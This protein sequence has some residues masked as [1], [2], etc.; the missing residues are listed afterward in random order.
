MPAY[1]GDDWNLAKDSNITGVE[2]LASLSLEA[3]VQKFIHISTL[4]VYG[5]PAE[6]DLDETSPIVLKHEQAY[7]ETKAESERI[8]ERYKE[9]GLCVTT[10]RPGAICAEE[11]SYWGD[12]QV[13]R[14]LATDVVNWVH[15]DDLVPW[16]HTDNLVEMIYLVSLKDVCGEVYNAIDG[17]Y[18][19]QEFRVKLI[20]ALGKKLCV[21]ER[22]IERPVYSNTKIKELGYQPVRTFEKTLA[23][24]EKLGL[25]QLG[26]MN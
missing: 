5:H 15:P 7:P 22:A 13:T 21:P 23:N 12:R 24:L 26:K 25:S 17:N 3:G 10:L 16:V 20:S 4:S 18:P 14:M 11:N 6:G 19:E 9:S 2:N 1:L 8:L